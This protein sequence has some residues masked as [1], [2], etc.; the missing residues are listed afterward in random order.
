MIHLSK[1]PNVLILCMCAFSFWLS[2]EPNDY[3]GNEDCVQ[4]G[5]IPDDGRP[6]TD[7]LNTW[8]DDT[9]TS[10]AFWICEKNISI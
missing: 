4:T 3:R 7:I 9:C 6:A 10:N 2:Q 1:A 8:N 5:Y